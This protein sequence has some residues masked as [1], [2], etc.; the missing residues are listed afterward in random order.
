MTASRPREIPLPTRDVLRYNVRAGRWILFDHAGHRLRELEP[1]G[2]E[3]LLI[4]ATI[5]AT[6]KGV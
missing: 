5:T 6:M 2:R 1:D 4:E 3:A